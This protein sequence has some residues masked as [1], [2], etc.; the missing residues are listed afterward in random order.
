MEWVAAASGKRGDPFA[1]GIPSWEPPDAPPMAAESGP[2]ERQGCTEGIR[3]AGS[4]KFSTFQSRSTSP[5]W[6]KDVAAVESAQQLVTFEDVAVCFTKG[7]WDL[8]EPEQKALYKEVMQENYENVASLGF[9]V[10]K[11]TLIFSLEQGAEPW[12]QDMGE[13]AI[14]ASDK[15]TAKKKATC[16]LCGKIV[17]SKY[18]LI[19]HTRTHTGEKPFECPDCRR[20]FAL[21]KNLTLHQKT[22]QKHLVPNSQLIQET[23]SCKES[24]FSQN[25]PG[26]QELQG[27]C[28]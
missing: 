5:P 4:E 3:F 23:A 27:K 21:R 9:P 20:R 25:Q 26:G 19:G 12:V 13:K 16:P 17:S 2:E 10:A 15:K 24:A 7:Q 14:K 8:L 18:A 1:G 11:P 6:E 22:H 28:F